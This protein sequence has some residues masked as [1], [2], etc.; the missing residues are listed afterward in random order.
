MSECLVACPVALGGISLYQA[1]SGEKLLRCAP[2]DMSVTLSRQS[3]ITTKYQAKTT[4]QTSPINLLFY[5]KKA[6]NWNRRRI[7]TT[8]ILMVKY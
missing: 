4:R 3:L 2:R 8:R 1:L 6:F 7:V 5:L